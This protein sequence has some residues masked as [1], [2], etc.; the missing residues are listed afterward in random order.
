M[1][2]QH[3]ADCNFIVA[4]MQRFGS[5]DP[6]HIALDRRCACGAPHHAQGL[7]KRHYWHSLRDQGRI[8]QGATSAASTAE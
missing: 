4:Y 5:L 6:P 1:I 3:H 2:P 8:S 7:C